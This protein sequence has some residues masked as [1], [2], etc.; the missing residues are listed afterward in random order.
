MLEGA[1]EIQ[2]GARDDRRRPPARSCSAPPGS[3]HTF[4]NPGPGD[5][6]FLRVRRA[7]RHRPLPGR[8]RRDLG[9]PGPPDV[10]G[11]RRAAHASSTPRRAM[12]AVPGPATTVLGPG[13]GES[14]TILG[15]SSRSRPT[16]PRPAARSASSTTPPP[17]GFPGPPPH[18]HHETADVFFVLEGELA[19]RSATR[20]SRSRP[21]GFVLVAPGTVHTFSNPA[22]RA[23]A[24]PRPGLSRPASSSTSATSRRVRRRP[25]RPAPCS[26]RSRPATTSS[27]PAPTEPCRTAIIPSAGEGE[28][29]TDR[30]ERTTRSSATTS[31]SP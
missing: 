19:L 15:S 11:A 12:G 9:R 3:P 13:E 6:R 30:P 2:A 28:T 7:G 1:L 20:R 22:D 17:P 16:P 27:T 31:L 26:A 10:R 21:D 18:V 29:I 24:L 23:R 8:A 25:A 5:A 14:M 4:T